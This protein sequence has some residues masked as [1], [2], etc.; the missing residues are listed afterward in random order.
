MVRKGMGELRDERREH[1]CDTKDDDTIQLHDDP[2][3]LF[4]HRNGCI[5]NVEM[6]LDHRRRCQCQPLVQTQV[7]VH[8]YKQSNM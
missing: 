3:C 7:L 1:G 6:G 5:V 8:I 4:E 2:L